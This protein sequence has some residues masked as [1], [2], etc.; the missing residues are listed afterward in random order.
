MPR[1]LP[2]STAEVAA[3]RRVL[4]VN[5]ESGRSGVV[6]AWK[7]ALRVTHPDTV[8]VSL[9]AVAEER[10]KAI[11]EAKQTL[12]EALDRGFPDGLKP[13]G[14]SLRDGP[15]RGQPPSAGRQGAA[16]GRGGSAGSHTPPSWAAT[17][18]PPRGGHESRVHVPA[19]PRWTPAEGRWLLVGALVVACLL[20]LAVVALT[21]DVGSGGSRIDTPGTTAPPK[22]EV[23]PVPTRP[24]DT[25]TPPSDIA[26]GAAPYAADFIATARE[27]PT[28]PAWQHAFVHPRARPVEVQDILLLLT[29]KSVTDDEV[30]LAARNVTCDLG[31]GPGTGQSRCTVAVP[32]DLID[33][34]EFR[35]DGDAWKLV[36]YWHGA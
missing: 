18:W 8:E 14:G 7:A 34:L 25:A 31:G 2:P 6:A 27:N 19:T 35:T 15:S 20:A 26:L 30:Q 3:A 11:N 24:G 32:A 12:I 36:G 23:R 28:D 1:R 9:K 17:A 10:T 5:G 13:A 33:D 16:T 4:G 21:R 22:P 29:D